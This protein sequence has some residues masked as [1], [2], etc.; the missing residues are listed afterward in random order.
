MADSEKDMDAAERALG[1]LPATKESP[2][3]RDLR[4]AWE[5]RLAPLLDVFAD[6]EPPQ[7][8]FARIEQAIAIDR[9]RAELSSA[10][11]HVRRWRGASLVAG[12]AA[13]AL[14]IWLAIPLAQP[15]ARYVAVVTSDSDGTT[16]LIIEFDTG[17][18]IATVIPAGASAPPGRALEMWH[19]PEGADRPHSLG[20]L[21]RNAELRR[22]IRTGEG[23][24][25]AISFEPP[26][27]SPTGQPTDPQYHGR[28]VKVE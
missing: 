22:T 4:S 7:G 15:P 26:G 8:F 27:G 25:F 17:S 19:L 18:G 23:D 13:A 20:L 5:M 24:L 10:Q 3:D 9:L 21:P 12:L 1:T 11:G 6:A 14:A 2:E 16:G 28:I